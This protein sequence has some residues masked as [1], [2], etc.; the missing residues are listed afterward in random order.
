V[1]IERGDDQHGCLRGYSG[2]KKKK[3]PCERERRTI[4]WGRFS[5]KGRSRPKTGDVKKKDSFRGEE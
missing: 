2:N 4:L 3:L 5:G 1:G